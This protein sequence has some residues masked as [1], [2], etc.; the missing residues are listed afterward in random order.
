MIL[1]L[2]DIRIGLVIS[3]RVGLMREKKTYLP[4]LSR[5]SRIVLFV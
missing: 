2:D 4:T 1:L 3:P 5:S